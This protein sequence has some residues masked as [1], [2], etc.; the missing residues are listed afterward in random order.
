MHGAYNLYISIVYVNLFVLP[1]QVSHSKQRCWLECN[2]ICF[3][4]VIQHS[5]LIL[6][7]TY[8]SNHIILPHSIF[9]FLH[10]T[11]RFH[12]MMK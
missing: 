10:S 4:V 7:N 5:H 8:P 2:F 12:S 11:E 3:L 6:F 9:S 1:N